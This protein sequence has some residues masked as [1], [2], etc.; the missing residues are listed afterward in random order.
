MGPWE[1]NK[2]AYYSLLPNMYAKGLEITV[3]IFSVTSWLTA[4]DPLL[5][6][7][8]FNPSIDK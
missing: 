2:I 1:T 3:T 5:T 6:S 8:N 4:G 7:N